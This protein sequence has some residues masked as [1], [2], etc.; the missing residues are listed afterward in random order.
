M[1]QTKQRVIALDYFRGICI[2][3]ILLSHSALY[4]RPYA[5]LSGTGRLW[6]SA[7]EFFFL[8]SGI[9][10]GVVRGGQVLS[11]FKSVRQK[12][13][14]RAKD[15]YL[16]YLLSAAVSLLIFSVIPL[17]AFM[18]YFG[19]GIVGVSKFS[20][21]F[22]ILSLQAL[23]GLANF[24]AFYAVYMVL[25]P[26]ALYGLYKYRRLWVVIPAISAAVFVLS[27]DYPFHLLSSGA[28]SSFGIWQ[29]YFVIG[30]V[31]ARFRQ[32]LIS[33]FYSL[34]RRITAVAYS[35]TTLAAAATLTVSLALGFNVAPILIRLTNEGWLPHKVYGAY[36]RL[37]NHRAI[38]DLLFMN[39]RTGLL[40]PLAA[41]IVLAGAYLFYQKHKKP[42]LRYTGRFVTAMG[43]DTLWV[44][45]AQAVV[46]PLMFALP[47]PTSI[48][49]SSL[50]AA[51]L[52]GS[53]WLVTQRATL[54]RLA[55]PYWRDFKQ[56]VWHNP[57][58]TQ[59]SAE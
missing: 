39:G 7:A 40:R 45:V 14:K 1:K 44:F 8:I 58:L 10:L 57:L 27:A 13:W 9:T 41:L 22:Q 35:T 21:L 31:L 25:A 18:S 34:N 15:L 49:Y 16:I 46:V 32:P 51:G 43:R 47:Q 53:M 54:L 50:L 20:L 26:F 4:T 30:M 3:V 2:L 23:V 33:R 29:F 24:L 6:V 28:Y 48:V 56:A 38:L 36:L 17:G 11:D 52:L 37:N 12:S 5:Y 42:I 59:E 19:F 55:K